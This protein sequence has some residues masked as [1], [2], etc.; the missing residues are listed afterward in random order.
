MKKHHD[1]GNIKK[2]VLYWGFAVPEVASKYHDGEHGSRQQEGM[3][4]EQ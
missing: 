2:K 4:L 1:Q 3:L